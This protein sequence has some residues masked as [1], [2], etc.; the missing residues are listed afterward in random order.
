[1][2]E[3]SLQ[4][5]D[6]SRE[7]LPLLKQRVVIG[8]SRESDIVLPDKWLSRRHAEIRQDDDGYYLSDL[9]SRN[10]TLLNGDRVREP[11]RLRPGDVIKL[12]EYVL[13]FS[14]EEPEDPEAATEQLEEFAGAQVFS[15]RWLSDVDTKPAVDAAELAR[16]SRVFGILTRAASA[17]LVHRPLGELFEF[18][19]D[20]LF[21]AVRAQRGAIMLLEGNPPRP[22][23]KASRTSEGPPISSLSRSITR[24]VLEQRVSL[25]IP[26][27]LE[28]ATFSTAASLLA[29]GIRS[30]LCAPLWFTGDSED[31]DAVI[32]LV[33]LDTLKDTHSFNEE[34]LRVLTA[35][36]N[37][38]AAK[39]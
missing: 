3:L 19:L 38:A 7:R 1:M 16:Q 5:A 27:V 17:L 34:D 24:R 33:Y 10:G 32:G 6:G 12:G 9:G 2:P 28:D 31:R 8:R 23:I 39:I 11:Q 26:N 15:P 13:T 14:W 22:V 4:T 21:E 35:L 37:V 20:R 30:A 29:T 18:V 36:A 25:L